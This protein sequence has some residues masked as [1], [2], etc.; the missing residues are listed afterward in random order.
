MGSSPSIDVGQQGNNGIVGISV[1]RE[2]LSPLTP[3]DYEKSTDSFIGYLDISSGTYPNVTYTP[4]LA[5]KDSTDNINIGIGGI[6]GGFGNKLGNVMNGGNNN[7]NGLFFGVGGGGGDGGSGGKGGVD[8]FVTHYDTLREL[9]RLDGGSYYHSCLDGSVEECTK[10]HAM[11]DP[12]P[13]PNR[14]VVSDGKSGK[15]GG[16]G[17]DGFITI[18]YMKLKKLRTIKK[19][20]GV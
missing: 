20:E 10:Q 18:R 4:Y 3:L 15:H 5:T 12:Q 6:G 16:K 13:G 1:K 7:S 11:T 19:V 14:M 17:G 9:N 2:I 8:Q